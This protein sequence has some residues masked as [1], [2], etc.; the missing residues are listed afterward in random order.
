MFTPIIVDGI[1]GII[2]LGFQS[3]QTHFLPIAFNFLFVFEGIK[4]TH[5]AHCTWFGAFWAIGSYSLQ[6]WQQQIIIWHVQAAFG[7]SLG[8]DLAQTAV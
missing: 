6:H 2:P 1:V 5:A 4:F 8:G 7:G 3:G